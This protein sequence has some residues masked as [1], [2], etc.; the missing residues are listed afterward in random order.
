MTLDEAESLTLKV[1]KQV[2]EE[3]LDQHN[4]QLAKVSAFSFFLVISSM[5]LTIHRLLPFPHHLGHASRRLPDSDRP[6]VDGRD[7][8]DG[9]RFSGYGRGNFIALFAESKGKYNL[10]AS[11]F[12]FPQIV[13][14]L[15]G[16]LSVSGQWWR[17]T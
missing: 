2:M 11:F 4:V 12:L 17:R 7:W 9:T 5:R 3:K 15:L 6:R 1:L 10:V 16:K 14:S 8:K 13:V